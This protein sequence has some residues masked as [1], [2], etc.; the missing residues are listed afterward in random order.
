MLWEPRNQSEMFWCLDFFHEGL[1]HRIHPTFLIDIDNCKSSSG[2]L[3][4]GL[5]NT[6]GWMKDSMLKNWCYSFLFIRIFLPRIWIVH[7]CQADYHKY[8]YQPSIPDK[9]F[10]IGHWN[11]VWTSKMKHGYAMDWRCLEVFQ[12]AISGVRD[13]GWSIRSSS[14]DYT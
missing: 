9:H 11:Y 7:V 10:N 2:K 3:V 12:A 4:D 5:M 1:C 14:I 13:F 8:T 6:S